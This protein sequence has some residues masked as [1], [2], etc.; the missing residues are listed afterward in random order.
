MLLSRNKVAYQALPEICLDLSRDLDRAFCLYFFVL[1]HCE[2]MLLCETWSSCRRNFAAVTAQNTCRTVSTTE[3]CVTKCMWET[4]DCRSKRS[5]RIGDSLGRQR[6]RSMAVR[7]RNEHGGSLNAK[8]VGCERH[9]ASSDC[10]A[11]ARGVLLRIFHGAYQDHRLL[12]HHVTAL[13]WALRVKP[14]PSRSSSS[15][16]LF[17]IS[18]MPSFWR[19]ALFRF[20]SSCFRMSCAADLH[21]AE[22]WPQTR[23]MLARL[24][25]IKSRTAS[26]DSKL[27][28]L[29]PSMVEGCILLDC[30]SAARIQRFVAC[31]K[32]AAR[33]E[34]PFMV[35]VN[36]NR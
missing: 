26:I 33:F 24:P 16:R 27:A 6:R 21:C 22:S 15:L 36:Q 23:S 12:F 19:F 5:E 7:A 3:I 17:S 10:R 35:A 18:A 31:L 2:V 30:S 11:C 13:V 8:S 28:R 1:T 14:A 25:R 9:P 4:A 29:A 20:S 34:S 32:A